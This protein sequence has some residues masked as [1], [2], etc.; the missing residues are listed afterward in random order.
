MGGRA[1]E[2]GGAARCR[3]HEETDMTMRTDGRPGRGPDAARTWTLCA[4]ALAGALALAGCDRGGGGAGGG[5]MTPPDD[6][7]GGPPTAG[8]A[9]APLVTAL[10]FDYALERA[11]ETPVGEIGSVPLEECPRAGCTADD[12]RDLAGREGTGMRDA[13]A[14]VTGTTGGPPL[15]RAFAGASATV[16]GAAFRRYGFW[17]EHGHAAVEIGA[18]DLSAEADGRRWTGTFEAAHAWAAGEASGTNPAGTGGATWTGIAE[19]ARTADFARLEGTA[20]LRI[21]DLS[22]PLVD[23][24]IDL[25]DG[26]DGVELRWAGMQL[27]GGAFARGAAGADRIEGRFHGPGHR[28]AF[29]TFDDGAHVGAFGAKRP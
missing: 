22:R 19:A 18:G 9:P 16:S 12:L 23:V 27:S 28:E 8:I 15:T 1:A 2:N 7:L 4:A 3:G 24:D 6:G 25:D 26:G 13:F 10:H 14:T 5:G 29:G 20:E 21:A 11:G 17:G